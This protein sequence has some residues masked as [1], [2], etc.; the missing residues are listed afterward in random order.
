MVVSIHLDPRKAHVR[1]RQ[2][3]AL[4]TVL[5][6]LDVPV[7]VMGDFNVEWG[8]ELEGYCTKLGLRPYEPMQSLVS[9][10]RLHRRLDWVLIGDGLTFEEYWTESTTLSDHNLVVAKIGLSMSNQG[11]DLD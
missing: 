9:F 11:S 10:P 7:I 5:K 3:D 6:S 8:S 4:H 1:A 2:V